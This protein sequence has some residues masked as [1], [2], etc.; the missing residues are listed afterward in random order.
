MKQVE[1]KTN[2]DE[3]LPLEAS[4]NRFCKVCSQEIHDITNKSAEEIEWLKTKSTNK[5][6][7]KT[8]VEQ[9]KNYQRYLRL[10]KIGIIGLLVIGSFYNNGVL[11]RNQPDKKTYK[12]ELLETDSTTIIIKGKIRE[13]NKWKIK[14]PLDATLKIYNQEGLVIKEVKTDKKGRFKIKIPKKVLGEEYSIL[15]TS[16]GYLNFTINKIKVED[17]TLKIVMKHKMIR[18]G[19]YF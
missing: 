11:A 6:C 16:V 18:V 12:I 1:C 9:I 7:V 3:M 8:N 10:K 19:Y 5:F 15:I 4:E 2:W 14:I 13:R 17:T